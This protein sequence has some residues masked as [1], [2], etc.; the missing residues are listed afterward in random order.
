MLKIVTFVTDNRMNGLR[1]IVEDF[2]VVKFKNN[3]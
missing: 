1:Y 3:N 2:A